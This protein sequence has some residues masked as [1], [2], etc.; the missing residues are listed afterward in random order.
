MTPTPYFVARLLTRIAEHGCFQEASRLVHIL[1]FES[2]SATK[3]RPI[4]GKAVNVMD[5]EETHDLR[6]DT[7]HAAILRL[8]QRQS[9][10]YYELT[11][12][13]RAIDALETWRQ[14][15]HEHLR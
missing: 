11:L 13:I 3:S 5:H 1:S 2:L 9:Q 7:E 14:M 10:G 6:D 4:L 12:L 8:L 15:E